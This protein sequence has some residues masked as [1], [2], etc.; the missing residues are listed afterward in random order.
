MFKSLESKKIV[1][2]ILIL[3]FVL[4][5]F[6]VF[7]RLRIGILFTKEATTHKTIVNL[8]GWKKTYIN[9]NAGI[10]VNLPKEMIVED[11]FYSESLPYV[12][13]ITPDY[14]SHIEM[15]RWSKEDFLEDDFL[16][17]EEYF[18]F[19]KD[20]NQSAGFWITGEK[21][22]VDGNT[23]YFMQTQIAKNTQKESQLLIEKEP[24]IYRFRLIE[25]QG[26][27]PNSKI[28]QQA[29]RSIKLTDPPK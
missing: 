26:D 3:F 15:T 19:R 28:L 25:F 2:G 7:V 23:A 14:S 1:T 4:I 27:T 16:N 22:K 10:K 24:Y 13:F 6:V 5:I 29:L 20:F 9:F 18:T 11:S 21:L 17:L 12:D 8:S